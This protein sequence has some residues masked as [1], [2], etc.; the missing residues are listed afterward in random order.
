[1]FCT[2]YTFH[3]RQYLSSYI[4]SS[5]YWNSSLPDK[6]ELSSDQIQ[7]MYRKLVTMSKTLLRKNPHK[8]IKSSENASLCFCPECIADRQ[9][10]L[11]FK[12]QFLEE[13]AE[14]KQKKQQKKYSQRSSSTTTI[15]NTSSNNNC[16]LHKNNIIDYSQELSRLHLLRK[17]ELSQF[18]KHLGLKEKSELTSM[19]ISE[20]RDILSTSAQWE[21]LRA[22]LESYTKQSWDTDMLKIKNDCKIC[23]CKDGAKDQII[24]TP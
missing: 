9:V 21:T 2:P 14:E 11:R 12:L 10:P 4:V 20:L 5:S 17:D 7:V 8:H 15:V 22:S 6:C 13:Q 18:W 23:K 3:R 1:M 19:Y 16:Y 24:T